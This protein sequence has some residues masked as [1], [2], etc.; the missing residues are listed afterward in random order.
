MA[1]LVCYNIV[2]LPVEQSAPVYP[3]LQVHVPPLHA[4]FPLHGSG[5]QGSTTATNN[6]DNLVHDINV[7]FCS[8]D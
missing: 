4:P 6:S 5:T 3:E 8:F 7:K 2:T 1:V